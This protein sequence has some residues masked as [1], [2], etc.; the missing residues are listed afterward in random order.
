MLV[1]SLISDGT[2]NIRGAEVTMFK[3]ISKQLNFKYNLT[4]PKRCC[5]F[6]R[7]KGEN[8][9]GMIGEMM[10]GFSDV[11]W[12]QMYLKA[13]HLKDMTVSYDDDK[14]CIIVSSHFMFLN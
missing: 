12:G 6:G 9:T 2:K 3:A 8:S 10:L 4:E 13:W 7:R 14:A 11:G 5:G 1:T